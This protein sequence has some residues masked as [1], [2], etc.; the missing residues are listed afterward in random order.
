MRNIESA[1]ENKQIQLL[2]NIY[3]KLH[4]EVM[5]R[6]GKMTLKIPEYKGFLTMNE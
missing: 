1:N 2:N 4:F 3:D 6:I 5:W